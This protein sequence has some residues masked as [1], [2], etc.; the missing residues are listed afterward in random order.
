MAHDGPEPAGTRPGRATRPQGSG[1]EVAGFAT[2]LTGLLLVIGFWSGVLLA[3]FTLGLLVS[4]LGAALSAVA[5]VLR[6][7]RGRRARWATAGL[8]CGVLGSFGPLLLVVYAVEQH[9]R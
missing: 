9:V 6:R 1:L 8:V 4:A 2:G 7:R 5:L 3:A